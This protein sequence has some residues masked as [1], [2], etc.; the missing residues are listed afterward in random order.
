MKIRRL[1]QEMMRK[2][3]LGRDDRHA[4]DIQGI[5]VRACNIGRNEF[6]CPAFS[7]DWNHEWIYRPDAHTVRVLLHRLD[8]YINKRAIANRRK[9][10]R[11]TEQ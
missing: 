8:E 5:W 4:V 10:L 2:L 3:D 9:R 1:L 11:E 6:R 7:D